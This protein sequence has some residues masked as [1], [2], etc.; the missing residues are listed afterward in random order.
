MSQE[1]KD[2][3]EG[4]KALRAIRVLRPLK[5]VSGIP[6]KFNIFNRFCRTLNLVS[7][8]RICSREQRRKQ[9]GRL[10]TSP[11]NHNHFLLVRAKQIAKW[12]KALGTLSKHN[13]NL[14]MTAMNTMKL[15]IL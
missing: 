10:L 15:I 7:T 3:S 11:P 8:R 2:N 9:V 14:T 6:S 1:T 12:K 13:G 4:I 5:L